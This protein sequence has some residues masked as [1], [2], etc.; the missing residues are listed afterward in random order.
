M[1]FVDLSLYDKPTTKATKPGIELI[2]N[3]SGER[4][5]IVDTGEGSE[6][7][8]VDFLKGKRNLESIPGIVVRNNIDGRQDL[9]DLGID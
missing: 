1:S 4:R 7:L 8:M 3:H 9:V 6:R 2:D 5:I